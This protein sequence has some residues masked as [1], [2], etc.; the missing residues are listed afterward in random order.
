MKVN[1]L[2]FVEDRYADNILYIA[3]LE[4]GERITVLDR[5]TGFDWCR[6]DIE[7]GYGDLEGKF[8]LVSGNFDIRNYPDLDISDAIE[9]IKSN[10]N[11][12]RGD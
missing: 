1:E 11:I 3:K 7:T 4:S 9:L 8:W 10:A 5:E 6:R 12:C 2:V